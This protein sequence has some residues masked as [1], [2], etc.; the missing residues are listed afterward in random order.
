MIRYKDKELHELTYQECTEF[1]KELL[2]KILAASRAQMA[3]PIIDQ[4]QV[5]NQMLQDQK[6]IALMKEADGMQ[7]SKP[8]GVS[9]DT[10]PTP[11]IDEEED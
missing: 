10:D 3:E 2:R 11:E 6:K 7:Q 1:E 4:L 8:D 9:V 5:F